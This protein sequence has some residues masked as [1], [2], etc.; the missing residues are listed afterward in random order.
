MESERWK[1]FFERKK[2]WSYSTN[3][4]LSVKRL[5]EGWFPWIVGKGCEKSLTTE[6]VKDTGKLSDPD[7]AFHDLE[8][9]ALLF[10]VNVT[11]D[12]TRLYSESHKLG[13]RP[14][15]ANMNLSATQFYVCV[16]LKH[17][18][19]MPLFI[20][21]DEA[22]RQIP[23]KTYRMVVDGDNTE[24]LMKYVPIHMWRPLEKMKQEIDELLRKHYTIRS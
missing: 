8:T 21:V 15:Q 14:E 6:Y 1:R 10:Y 24:Q 11:S 2:I 18:P 17:K 7:L 19:P 16:L 20:R 22:I 9:G 3:I 13:I 23:S 12:K 4:E 5:I